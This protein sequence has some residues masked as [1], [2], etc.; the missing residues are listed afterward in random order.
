M[1]IS[2]EL[3]NQT[4]KLS[5]QIDAIA[6]TADDDGLYDIIIHLKSTDAE[7]DSYRQTMNAGA[8]AFRNRALITN[9]HDLL[10]P[11]AD[12]MLRSERTD[13]DITRLRKSEL[14]LAS[15]IALL[16]TQNIIPNID[17]KKNEN[18]V[19]VN[20]F[21]DQINIRPYIQR[22]EDKTKDKFQTEY[23]PKIFWS[24]DSIRVAVEKDYLP[25]LISDETI[26][27]NI[28]GVYLNRRLGPPRY[29]LGGKLGDSSQMERATWGVQ[30][31]GTLAAWGAFENKGSDIKIAVLD[32]GV[33]PSHPD[34]IDKIVG[35]AEF[36][37][38]GRKV[39]GSN[40]HDTDVHGT[41]VCGTIAGS[42]QSGRFIGVAPEAE[43]Y[44]GLV[45]HGEHG[46]T[47]AQ[48]LGG[49]DWAIEEGVDIINLSLGGLTLDRIVRSPFH[50]AVFSAA[51]AGISVVAAVGND[52]NQTSGT[53]GNDFF[54]FSV[55]AVDINDR[56]A[57]FSGGRTHLID[58]SPYIDNQ[59]LPLVYSKP[60]ICAPGVDIISSVPDH[61]SESK[62]WAELSGTSMA[63]PHVSGAIAL[64][65]SAC[66]KL[67]YL[68]AVERA[69]VI[70]DIVLGTC[71]DLGERGQDHRFGF[72]R[73][74]ILRALDAAKSLGY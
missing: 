58:Q 20:S 35:W 57:G 27:D 60:D 64:L 4:P 69:S 33:D 19:R 62:F 28:A 2:S 43:I 65:R 44:A 68:P 8:Q 49:I 46:G 14:S 17:I 59:Y 30:R 70:Q 53:P 23:R 21:F 5:D 52:G 54:T 63:T 42:N 22:V 61:Q 48:I 73:L 6:S 50:R 25:N 47:E 13:E 40:P 72:G 29:M 3:E 24:S 37:D 36:D 56:C 66:P 32:T 9:L 74:D 7:R 38:G 18:K 26:A 67:Q 45:L 11:A 15:R 51:Q 55:G 39:T 10:P 71:H 31:I 34:L 41:H 16:G 12:S 1:Y